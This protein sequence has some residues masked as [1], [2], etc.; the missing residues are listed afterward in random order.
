M[1]TRE[2]FL[3]TMRFNTKVRVPKWE[4]AYWGSTIK[5]C[6]AEGLPEKSYPTIPTRVQTINAS[7]YTVAYTHAWKKIKNLFEKVFGEREKNRFARWDFG[8]GRRSLLADP[9]HAD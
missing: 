5:R 7:L 8:V 9:R 3:E 2:R 6:Y 4:F 1:N